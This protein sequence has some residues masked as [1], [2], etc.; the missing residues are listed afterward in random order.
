M[1]HVAQFTPS[2]CPAMFLSVASPTKPRSHWMKRPATEPTIPL[3]QLSHWATG[4]TPT[5]PLK[6]LVLSHWSHSY[7]ATEATHWSYSYWA[8]EATPSEPPEPLLLSHSFWA[9]PSEPLAP[10]A[11]LDVRNHVTPHNIS[12]LVPVASCVQWAISLRILDPWSSSLA[13][14]MRG[15]GILIWLAPDHVIHR[16]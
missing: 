16:T 2:T 12:I 9:T 7:W 1:L 3:S 5:E 11:P 10:L 4:A 8:T 14:S 6:P 13:C 15:S